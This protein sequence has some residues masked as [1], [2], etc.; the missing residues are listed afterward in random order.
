MLLEPVIIDPDGDTFTVSYSGW[1]TSP[2][3]TTGFEDAGT[4]I[5]TITAT[6]SKGSAG[7]LDVKIVVE[8]YNRPPE[9]IIE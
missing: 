1:M 3:K 6:D 9:L 5:V 2:E 8:D 7:S 4:H